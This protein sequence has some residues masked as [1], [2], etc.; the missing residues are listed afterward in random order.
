MTVQCVSVLGSWE[1]GPC[2]RSTPSFLSRTRVT[3]KRLQPSC[4]STATRAIPRQWSAAGSR[5]DTERNEVALLRSSPDNVRTFQGVQMLLQIAE[6]PT[7]SRNDGSEAAD[8][9]R[10]AF[11]ADTLAPAGRDIADRRIPLPLREARGTGTPADSAIRCSLPYAKRRTWTVRQTPYARYLGRRFAQSRRDR[12]A[13]PRMGIPPTRKAPVNSPPST[14]QL[15]RFD[16]HRQPS[17][18]A[19]RKA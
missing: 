17:F 15:R 6:D 19:H 3:R 13:H 16:R 8:R 4:A 7:T 2:N 5:P 18:R 9:P 12:Q 1:G 14:R 11:G 10:L